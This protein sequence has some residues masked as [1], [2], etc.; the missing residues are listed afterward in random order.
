MTR[1]VEHEHLPLGVSRPKR[2]H[3]WQP[4][5]VVEGQ[6]MEQDERWAVVGTALQKAAEPRCAEDPTLDGW[7]S[8]LEGRG[9]DPPTFRDVVTLHRNVTA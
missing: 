8:V 4:H 5:A 3:G 9:H 6:P 1:E 7:R 2:I